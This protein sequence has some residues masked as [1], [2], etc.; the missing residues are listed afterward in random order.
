MQSF[1]REER[2]VAPPVLQF[3]SVFVL[4]L[5]TRDHNWFPAIYIPF[6]LS[7]WPPCQTLNLNNLSKLQGLSRS[8]DPVKMQLHS[9]LCILRH[10]PRYIDKCT[11]AS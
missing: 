4:L 1:P 3:H 10:S 7:E 5:Y 2:R 8:F 9:P 11:R 6:I